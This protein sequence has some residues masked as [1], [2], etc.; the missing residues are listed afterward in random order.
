MATLK[1]NL[2]WLAGAAVVMSLLLVAFEIRQNTNALAA[3][4]VFELN[5]AGRDNLFM[6]VSD[7]ELAGMLERAESDPNSLT[8]EERYIY[9]LWVFSRVNLFESAWNHHTR[10]I[11]SDD[12]M[13]GWKSDFCNAVSVKAFQTEMSTIDAHSPMFL[14]DISQWCD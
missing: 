2:E 1:D 4:A 3:Q 11:I 8:A 13:E 14:S 10:G 6:Q 9:R 12:D 7:R 5:Q